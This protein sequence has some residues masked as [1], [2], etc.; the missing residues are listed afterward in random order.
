MDEVLALLRSAFALHRGQMRA[1]VLAACAPAFGWA[2]DYAC[3]AMVFMSGPHGLDAV[4]EQCAGHALQI[5]RLSCNDAA[6]DQQIALLFPRH[7]L[8]PMLE[9]RKHKVKRMVRMEESDAPKRSWS[10]PVRRF[11]KA[12]YA[13]YTHQLHASDTG[14]LHA[15]CLLP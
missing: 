5:T 3:D 2:V 4:F 15:A 1:E 12:F 9:V 14:D 11:Y 6:A 8:P 13:L 10:P 7:G